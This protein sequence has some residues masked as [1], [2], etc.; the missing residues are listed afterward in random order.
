MMVSPELLPFFTGIALGFAL[1]LEINCRCKGCYMPSYVICNC[2]FVNSNIYADFCACKYLQAQNCILKSRGHGKAVLLPASQQSLHELYGLQ[3]FWSCC[4]RLCSVFLRAK[5]GRLHWC[6]LRDHP[7][8]WNRQRSLN[9]FPR[10]T[11]H[12][13]L[14]T[15]GVKQK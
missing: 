2:N 5:G 1:S 11:S 4:V 15:T 6:T 3:L 8:V 13:A 7:N 12:S 10:R 14:R 9:F